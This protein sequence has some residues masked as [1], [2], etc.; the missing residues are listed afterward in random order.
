MVLL[1]ALAGCGRDP[2]YVPLPAQRTPSGA[3]DPGVLGNS[4]KMDDAAASGYIVRDVSDELSPWRWTFVH[5][6]LKLVPDGA[7]NLKFWMEI[8]IPP[9]T[10]NVTGPVTLTCFLDGRPL[11][12]MR[13]ASAGRHRYERPV[14]EGWVQAGKAVKVTA[15][16]DKRWVSKD[17]G[18]QLGFLLNAVGITQ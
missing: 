3:P 6:E 12:A 11:G 10:F 18:A 17:D 5:P 9:V 7:H 14:P 16:V 13:C 2:G 4:V 1:L 8:A 15:E